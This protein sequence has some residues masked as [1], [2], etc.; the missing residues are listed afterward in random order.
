MRELCMEGAFL[1]HYNW[2]VEAPCERQDTRDRA[3][4]V[5]AGHTRAG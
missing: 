2:A 3:R 1:F 4:A 5:A